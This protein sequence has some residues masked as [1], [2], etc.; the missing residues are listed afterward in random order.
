MRLE[1]KQIIQSAAINSPMDKP[2]PPRV[3]GLEVFLDESGKLTI[4]GTI[5]IRN[6]SVVHFTYE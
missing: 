5:A 1:Q 3:D 4:K 6:Y 2:E